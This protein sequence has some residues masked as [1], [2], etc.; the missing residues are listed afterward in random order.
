ML[1]AF[2]ISKGLVTVLILLDME[3]GENCDTV[4]SEINFLIPSQIFLKF[5]RLL[6]N[7]FVK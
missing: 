6:L 4:L 3:E 5:F 7:K 1:K 2:A